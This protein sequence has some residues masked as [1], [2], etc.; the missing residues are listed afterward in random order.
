[1][2]ARTPNPT[3]HAEVG[4]GHSRTCGCH[5][6]LGHWNRDADICL[7]W[8]DGRTELMSPTTHR[9]EDDMT[10]DTETTPARRGEHR[11]VLVTF[12]VGALTVIGLG[13]VLFSQHRQSVRDDAA[14]VVR[15]DI[16][17]L[18]DG[19]NRA[20]DETGKFG[21]TYVEN[22][23]LTKRS[24]REY[25]GG[26]FDDHTYCLYM[27]DTKTHVTVIYQSATDTIKQVDDIDDPYTYEA[28]FCIPE[29]QQL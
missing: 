23:K 15:A 2:T 19:Y 3:T 29:K 14:A 17:T 22:A 8:I 21:I 13:G 28:P 27:V 5:L 4:F 12:L 11:V 25:T 26:I 20:Y 1:M 10:T 16:R 9:G 18:A 6:R 7:A 24:A